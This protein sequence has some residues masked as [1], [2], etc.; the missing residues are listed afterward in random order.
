M[1]HLVFAFG[2]AA[3]ALVWALTVSAPGSSFW[4]VLAALAFMLAIEGLLA[5]WGRVV[6]LPLLLIIALPDVALAAEPV[7]VGSL[8]GD[9]RET[10][11][12][13]L[14]VAA[15]GLAAVIAFGVHRL[16]GVKVD[17]GARKA[18]QSAMEHGI[19]VGLA[20][21]QGAADRANPALL[22]SQAV[23]VALGYV[24]EFAPG[25]VRHFGLTEAALVTLLRAQLAKALPIDTSAIEK[26]A[27]RI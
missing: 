6:L 27:V 5:R 9:L 22:Q 18:L 8:F 14:T 12:A 17:E 21:I 3:A 25:A 10:I 13:V 2:F 1:H 26:A 7:T 23:Q 24:R 16:T 4:V 15:S 19:Q 20:A 11:A